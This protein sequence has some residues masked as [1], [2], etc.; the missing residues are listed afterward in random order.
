MVDIFLLQDHNA[1]GQLP[2]TGQAPFKITV[3]GI[4]DLPEETAQKSRKLKKKQNQYDN[5]YREQEWG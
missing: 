4:E 1:F 2:A 5:L 3:R